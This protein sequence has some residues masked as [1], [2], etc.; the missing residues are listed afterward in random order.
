MED[1]ESKEGEIL[2][3]KE[4][5]EKA[6]SLKEEMEN[7]QEEILV[8]K[9]KL[10]E[11]KTTLLVRTTLLNFSREKFEEQ[12]QELKSY[13][14]LFGDL[15]AAVVLPQTPCVGSFLKKRGGGIV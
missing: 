6:N 3:L 14:R 2:A 4:K 15:S 5:L 1:M 8:L 12:Q 9:D 10:G 7:K 13:K 11:A